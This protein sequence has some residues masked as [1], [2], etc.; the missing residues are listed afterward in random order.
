ME[1]KEEVRGE[2]EEEG[3]EGKEEEENDDDDEDEDGDKV[4]DEIITEFTG[5]NIGKDLIDDDKTVIF[6][7]KT[8]SQPSLSTRSVCAPP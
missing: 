3:E 6:P 2:G 1:D 8:S 5:C 7:Q 4:V